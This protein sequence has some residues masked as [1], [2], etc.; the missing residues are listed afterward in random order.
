MEKL[1]TYTYMRVRTISDKV[2]RG[3][4]IEREQGGV[5]DRVRREQTKR[6]GQDESFHRL[7]KSN[8]ESRVFK[9]DLLRTSRYT[10]KED[11]GQN[12][13]LQSGWGGK[14]ARLQELCSGYHSGGFPSSRP[15]SGL[16]QGMA[17]WGNDQGR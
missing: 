10:E 6:K 2:K 11:A 14:R 4:D 8:L 7:C 5:H 13:Q 9:Q 1:Q 15:K 12:S 17:V 16:T 3:H